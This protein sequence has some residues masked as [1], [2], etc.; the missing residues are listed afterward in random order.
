MPSPFTILEILACSLISFLPYMVLIVY[1]FRKHLRFGN[2]LTVT[3]AVFAAVIQLVCDVAVG[4]KLMPNAS[5]LLIAT[6]V[7]HLLLSL[8]LIRVPFGKKLFALIAAIGSA[9]V[10]STASKYL[11]QT[12]FPDAGSGMFRWIFLLMLVALE[13]VILVPYALMVVKQNDNAKAGFPWGCLLLIPAAALAVWVYTALPNFTS[14]QLIFL[15]V[16][17][18]NI[19]AILAVRGI[20]QTVPKQS[21]PQAVE[22]PAA[23]APKAKPVK[24]PT[25]PK[26]A[27]VAAPEQ[28]VMQPAVQEAPAPK[29]APAP[30]KAPAPKA[31]Q[32]MPAAPAA[33]PKAEIKSPVQQ[34]LT[35]DHLAQLQ[36]LQ[37]DSLMLRIRESDQFHRELRRHVDAMAYRLDRKQFEKLQMHVR[38]LQ[39]Q[40]SGEDENAFCDNRELNTVLTYYNRMAGYCGTMVTASMQVDEKPAVDVEDLTVLLGNLLDNALEA[41]GKQTS[42]DR[43]IFTAIRMNGSSLYLTVE[44]TYD[45]PI[46]KSASGR[47]LSTKHSG[48]GVGLEVCEQI[49]ARHNGTLELNDFNG[50][51]K[52]TAIL[53]P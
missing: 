53:R 37:R 41:C 39:E 6:L 4:L 32:P 49:V 13:A 22:A 17:P 16:I 8:V 42:R 50:I 10:L 45:S 26:E 5:T 29:A 44:N 43:R 51:F 30:K 31:P 47:Y 20:L 40:L 7:I 9:V 24:K 15:V 23:P 46:Q 12:L 3:L 27:P 21:A 48:Y 38:S 18:L 35:R 19:F 33:A 1:P 25:A 14:L 34:T 36:S 28:P 52:A 11:T 2:G